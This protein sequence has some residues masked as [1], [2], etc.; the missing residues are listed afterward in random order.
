M[1]GTKQVTKTGSPS[2]HTHTYITL[3]ISPCRY[4]TVHLIS[5]ISCVV[6]GRGVLTGH[7]G[8]G[9]GELYL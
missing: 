1:N 7:C 5:V 4:L 8:G 9:G 2:A 6:H 3:T